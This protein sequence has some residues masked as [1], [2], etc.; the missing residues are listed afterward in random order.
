MNR[1]ICFGE[2]LVDQVHTEKG[3]LN[4]PGGA[5]A[6]V[7]TNIARLGGT[8]RFL[9]AISNDQLGTVLLDA[10]ERAKVDTSSIIRTDKPTARAEITLENQGERH[11]QF[12]CE[13]TAD[14]AFQAADFTNHALSGQ[15][16]HF[17]SNSMTTESSWK[18]TLFGVQKAKKNGHFVSFDL[19]WRPPFWKNWPARLGDPLERIWHVLEWVDLLKLS[20]E[21]FDQL[22]EKALS[23]LEQ[24]PVAHLII[25]QGARGAK[26]L[27]LPTHSSQSF[28]ARR[29]TCRD[30]TGAGDA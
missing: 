23:R 26:W 7:A 2:A 27:H 29:V 17:G 13:D 24:T 1:V 14:Q 25:T 4:Y 15:F 20:E 9:G 11:F 3:L 21:E 8:S 28:P 16:F 12:F 10:L 19:N 18:T 5:P 22:G 6:N 30:S